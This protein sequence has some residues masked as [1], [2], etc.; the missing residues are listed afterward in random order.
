MIS[1]LA[2]VRALLGVLQQLVRAQALRIEVRIEAVLHAIEQRHHAA[3]VGIGGYVLLRCRSVRCARSPRRQSRSAIPLRSA[4]SYRGETRSRSAKARCAPRRRSARS[5]GAAETE[6]DGCR[7]DWAG[8]L[9]PSDIA[10][11]KRIASVAPLRM[12]RFTLTRGTT[13]SSLPA[14]PA[15]RRRP[16]G[17]C[18]R[19]AANIARARSPPS[20]DEIASV[21]GSRLGTR[22]A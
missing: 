12:I 1:G 5:C 10:T 14:P 21:R 17:H 22:Q 6:C 20:F 3:G 7:P 9:T 16:A 2:P 13:E 19:D 11:A 8:P 15:W 18:T 4:V